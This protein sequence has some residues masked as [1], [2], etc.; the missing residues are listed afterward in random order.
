[1]SSS[2]PLDLLQGEERILSA[3]ELETYIDDLLDQPDLEITPPDALVS[4]TYKWSGRDLDQIKAMANNLPAAVVR[5]KGFVEAEDRV[6]IFSYVMGDWTL[7]NPGIPLERIKHKNIVVFIAPIDTMED[8][9][10]ALQTGNWLKGEV[11]WPG[12]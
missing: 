3:S 6:Y 1:M 10:R 2:P 11:C 8:I 7:E 5:A 12:S 9:D 4:V